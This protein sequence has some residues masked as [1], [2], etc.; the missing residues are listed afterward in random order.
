MI[1]TIWLVQNDSKTK[2]ICLGLL[3]LKG[4]LKEKQKLK[5]PLDTFDQI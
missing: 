3:K 4:P 5:V 2:K 1:S